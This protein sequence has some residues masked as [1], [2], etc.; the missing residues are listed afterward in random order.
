MTPKVLLVVDW[1]PPVGAGQ[2][3]GAAATAL[4][5]AKVAA[6]REKRMLI[7]LRKWVEKKI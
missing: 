7:K 5:Q 6:A 1:L 3:A 2:A 4:A